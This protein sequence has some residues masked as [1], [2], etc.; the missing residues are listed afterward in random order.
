M[1]SQEDIYIRIEAYLD[2]QLQGQDLVD[3]E[4]QLASDP[5]FAK[6]V[7][8]HRSVQQAM[9]AH[10]EIAFASNLAEIGRQNGNVAPNL[11]PPTPKPKMRLILGLVASILLL[12]AIGWFLSVQLEKV[13]T[14]EDLFATYFEPY[15]G[16]PT[17][18]GVVPESALNTA[19]APYT[20][21]D[22][23]ASLNQ[24][25][26]L[27]LQYPKNEQVMFYA[28]IC[29]LALDNPVAARNSFSQV[30]ALPDQQSQVQTQWYLAMAWLHT[31]DGDQAKPLLLE[32][33][34]FPNKYQTQAKE[35]LAEL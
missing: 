15:Q 25:M 21:G 13:Q 4:A 17:F 2:D 32:L 11:S 9:S 31:G 26:E 7:D 3:F 30:L 19:L 33:E 10:G 27:D 18:R 5:E 20:D 29:E 16:P 6:Q 8:L 35:I 12:F 24:L 22:F 23:Q 34:A 28:G 14:P 1:A